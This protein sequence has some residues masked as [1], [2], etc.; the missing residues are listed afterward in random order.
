LANRGAPFFFARVRRIGIHCFFEGIEMGCRAGS[1][2]RGL[3]DPPGTGWPGQIF[4]DRCWQ[5]GPLSQ[6]EGE[7]LAVL[8]LCG[9]PHP[10]YKLP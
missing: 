10:Q 9:T 8:G 6:K 5:E 1:T 7:R 2:V 3:F 4:F